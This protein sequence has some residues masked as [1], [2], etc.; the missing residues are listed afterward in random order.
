MFYLDHESK[1]P[2]VISFDALQTFEVQIFLQV[3]I[4]FRPSK[5][6]KRKF[7]NYEH[8]INLEERKNR[9]LG[10]LSQPTMRNKKTKTVRLCCERSSLIR[11]I[12]RITIPFFVRKLRAD[13][14]NTTYTYRV[15][16]CGKR[17]RKLWKRAERRVSARF[18]ARR[19]PH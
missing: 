3:S 13:Y 17:V 11:K 16:D 1:L 6:R 15:I 10:T 2:T 9:R 5:N 18:S 8:V 4:T 19:F 7:T 14:E 12:G